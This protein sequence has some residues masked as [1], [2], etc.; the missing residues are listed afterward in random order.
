MLTSGP[1]VVEWVSSRINTAFTPLAVG[2]GWDH[3]GFIAGAVFDQYTG[4]NIYMH[5]AKL[6][7]WQLMPTFVAAI[8]D[9]SLIHI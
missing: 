9:L 7:G 4:G 3:G 8:M 5:C 2:L 6:R 1:G